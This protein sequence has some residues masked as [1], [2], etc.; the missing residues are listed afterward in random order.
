MSALPGKPGVVRKPPSAR[1][2]LFGQRENIVKSMNRY[3][4]PVPVFSYEMPV[5]L[6]FLMPDSSSTVTLADTVTVVGRAIDTWYGTLDGRRMLPGYTSSHSSQIVFVRI[7]NDPLMVGPLHP[8]LRIDCQVPWIAMK[9]LHPCGSAIGFPAKQFWSLA[10][11][12]RYATILRP[13]TGCVAATMLTALRDMLV[14]G[15]SSCGMLPGAADWHEPMALI[16][17]VLEKS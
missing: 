16:V 3:L 9:Y 13:G 8:Q 12:P 15:M 2:R 4:D 6:K 5:R 11:V 14:R 17:G 7:S 10:P 1:V